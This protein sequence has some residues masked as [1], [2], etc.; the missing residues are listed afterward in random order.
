L[1]ARHQPDD[2]T[3]LYSAQYI[4]AHFIRPCSE[5]NINVPEQDWVIYPDP[6]TPAP[7][8]DNVLR[9][10][11]SGCDKGAAEFERVRVQYRPI[12]GDG[13]WINITPVSDVL[14][15]GLGNTFTQFFWDTEGLADGPYEVRAIAVCNGDA[16]DKPGYSQVI[17]GKID[18]QPPSIVGTP[19]PSD[20]VYNV[21]DEVSVTFNKDIN[22]NKIFQALIGDPNNVGLYDATT[23]LLIDAQISCFENKI[24][25]VPNFQN[26][27]FEN[28]I[29]RLELHD[30]PDR[31]G[32]VLAAFDWEFYVDRNELAWLT[33]SVGMT[34]FE[35]QT[36]TATASIHNRGGYPV[37]FKITGAPSWVRVVPSAGT[38]VANQVLPITF[39]VDSTLAFGNW[40]D[41]VTLHTET[42]QNPFFMGGD[43]KLPI[44]VR[45]VCRPPNW[46]V[47]P[48][49]FENTMNMVI[50]LDIQGVVS[51]DA[52][53]IVAAY[54]GDQMRGS[55]YLEYSPEVNKY[56]AYLTMYGN[57]DDQLD[58]VRFEI[59][60]ASECLRYEAVET[61]TFQ[62]DNVIGFIGSPVVLHTT[63]LVLREVPFG[64][65]WNWLSFNLAFPVN[66]INAA[67]TSLKHP[68]NDLMKSQTSFST[69]SGG[70]FGTLNNLGNTSMYIYRADV[71][72]TLRMVGNL[73]NPATTNIPV[74]TGWNWIGYVPSYSLPT[75]E[76]LSSLP[77]QP[78]DLIKGQL[79]F[80][81]YF[82]STFGWVGNLKYMS[83][84][85][86]YQIKVATP[87][88]LTYP[89]P[90]QQR[91]GD[92]ATESREPQI[93]AFWNVNAAQ[94]EHSMTLIGMLKVNGQN[95]TTAPMELGVFAGTEVRG[96]AQAIYIAPLNAYLFFLTTYANA[97]GEQLKFKLFDS[98]TGA[99][100]EL[101]ETMWFSPNLHQGSIELPMPFTLK[102]SGLAEVAV[103]QSFD[104]Q[105]NPFSTETMFR[106][107]LSH[108]QE[109]T[110]SVSDASGR[111]VS[112]LRTQA[113][114]GLNTVTWDGT[115][116][117][118][119]R[120][121]AGVYF[122]RLNTED[123]M[124]TRKVVLQR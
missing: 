5:V 115:S 66:S 114:S 20:G 24:T 43:E 68:E 69:Y 6:T 2:D 59:W 109:V 12:G 39:E 121:G 111:E 116:D 56:L 107:A 76:A 17:R 67:L 61:Y 71:P 110:I 103:E 83:P 35:N 122:V 15:A 51:T 64:F 36:K 30:I 42:G 117:A 60:D 97:G 96:S 44:G 29:L 57:P 84:P 105:P 58:P 75:N 118:G 37:P 26:E 28:H 11:T 87:G 50:Q 25:V 27:F 63:S 73:L 1:V 23:G 112:R 74:V 40:R 77:S 124:V 55:A 90:S 92:P 41:S 113:R 78:G 10:T 79:S 108:G 31:T 65:G 98:A 91:P 14:K 52:Q 19:Q 47:N 85:N 72:D 95:A 102:T 89:P 54:I 33:D 22:C 32:N 4:S 9:I 45:V 34:K 53:D 62:P 49:L 101:S 94:Y 7:G 82:N 99:V 120:L 38:L 16:A 21:G 3:I 100:Q 119:L 70:W 93:P 104:V 80:A 86:G 13:A 88:T 123:G 106:F 46:K 18:R 48:N 81:Q 8:T